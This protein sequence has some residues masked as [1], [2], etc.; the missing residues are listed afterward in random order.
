MNTIKYDIRCSN[1]KASTGGTLEVAKDLDPGML[2]E[3]MPGV[4]CQTCRPKYIESRLE[5]SR[6]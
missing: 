5:A 3:L 6:G 1:C 4:I 2:E